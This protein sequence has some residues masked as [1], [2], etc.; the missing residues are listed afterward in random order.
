MNLNKKKESNDFQFND[1]KDDQS[2]N[3]ITAKNKKV[4]NDNYDEQIAVDD[5]NNEGE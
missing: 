5:H 1:K 3:E 2:D 4:D